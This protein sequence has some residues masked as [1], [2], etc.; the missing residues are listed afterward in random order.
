LREYTVLLDPPVFMPSQ[1]EAQAQAPVTT[2]QAG[3]TSGG[4]IE[5]QAQQPPAETPSQATPLPTPAPAERTQEPVASSSP[6]AGTP[7]AGEYNVERN[8]TLWR[9]A[10]RV[11]PGA[12]RREV[13][14]TMIALFRAQPRGVQRQHQSPALRRGAANSGAVGHRSDFDVGRNCRG[15]TPG[16]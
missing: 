14:R 2:P 10:S 13:N 11:S 9:I 1:P 6:S 7:I 12:S 3:A 16:C 5:R 8:D 4:R 15:P